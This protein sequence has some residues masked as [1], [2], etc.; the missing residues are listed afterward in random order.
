MSLL[1]KELNQRLAEAQ[2]KMARI[3]ALCDDYAG[4]T[5]L[6][7]A[8]RAVLGRPGPAESEP[9][10]DPGYLALLRRRAL[11]ART[12][13]AWEYATTTGPR[14]QWD[15]PDRPPE[16]DGWELDYSRG[17][18]GEAWERFDYHEERYWKR[19]LPAEPEPGA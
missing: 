12:E 2:G 4:E 9:L 8:V 14:K 15:D 7:D 13:P 6:V 17:H 3:A 5:P 10:S 1:V 19:P 18:P 16:G 11:R